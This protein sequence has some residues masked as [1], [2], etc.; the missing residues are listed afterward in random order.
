MS[1]NQYKIEIE[2]PFETKR[3][4]EIAYNVLEVDKEPKRSGVTK[5]LYQK[6]TILIANFSAKLAKQLRVALTN[7]FEKLDLI[8]GTIE[9][10]GPPVSKEYNHY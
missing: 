5:I 6:D 8:S 10:L 9:M 4:A 7:F 3:L 1:E 2:I